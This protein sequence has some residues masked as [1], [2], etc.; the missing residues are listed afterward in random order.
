MDD[1]SK[2]FD[3]IGRHALV[4]GGASGIAAPVAP[5]WRASART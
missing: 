1:H 3:L 5:A 2:I 4:I